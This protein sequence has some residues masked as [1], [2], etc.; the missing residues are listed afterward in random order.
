MEKAKKAKPRES[1][2]TSLFDIT[3]SI[4]RGSERGI[5]EWDEQFAK[6]NMSL[7]KPISKG[8]PWPSFSEVEIQAILKLHFEIL[9]FS[10][11]WR[12]RED[13]ANEK[14]I[15]LECRR[16]SDG[17][18]IIVAVKKKPKKNDLG[19][20]LELSQGDAHERMYVYVNGA[21]Q[22]FRDQRE[23]FA[24][25]VGFW[26]EKIL[27]ERLNESDLTLKLKADN[28]PAKMAMFR[29]MKGII[30]VI[31]NQPSNTPS[32][33][34]SQ[35]L[36]RMLWDMKDR[37]VTVNRC[38]SMAQLMF[39]DSSRFG[40]L[41]DIKAQ[42]LMVWCLDFIY[43]YGLNSLQSVFVALPR[44]LKELLSCVHE[45]TKVRSN[46][47]QLF[48][49]DPGLI[50]GRVEDACG[51]YEQLIASWKNN[52]EKLQS[53]PAEDDISEPAYTELEEV[54]DELRRLGIWADGLEGT[55]D[56]L[57]EEYVHLSQYK[58]RHADS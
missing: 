38:L 35:E 31:D 27:E 34:P 24:S 53:I 1:S 25:E 40:D 36:M 46:W 30:E 26:D 48:T 21:A 54:A 28:S 47:L 57:F 58:R 5:Q 13:P 39:E 3:T 14:G 23:T 55:I 42:N 15:D 7:G 29:I 11:I 22:S 20:V 49:Y 51:K 4:L 10:V 43:T 32:Q 18:K 19:Q 17:K 37:A 9:G 45:N 2:N 50:P 52:T 12:H 33:P 44:E 8:I 41:S 6:L 16:D 56:S